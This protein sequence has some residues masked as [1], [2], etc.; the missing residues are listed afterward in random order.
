MHPDISA[1]DYDLNGQQYYR[2][3]RAELY[4]NNGRSESWVRD[5]HFLGSI[6]FAHT[7]VYVL[8]PQLQLSL[9]SSLSLVGGGSGHFNQELVP[10]LGVVLGLGYRLS[11]GE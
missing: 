6:G 4:F 9:K 5:R 8:F 7:M 3:Q 10:R 2:H 11:G 1:Y